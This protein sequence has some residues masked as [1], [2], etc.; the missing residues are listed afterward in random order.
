M[1]IR[2]SDCVE[3]FVQ[4]TAVQ[5]DLSPGDISL[6]SLLLKETFVQGDFCLRC[7][8]QIFMAVHIILFHPMIN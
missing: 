6:M 2:L 8:F 7:K 3:A 5:G 1:N 4:Q